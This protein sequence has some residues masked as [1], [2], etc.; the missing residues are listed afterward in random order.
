MEER[1]AYLE[2][3]IPMF[4][5]PVSTPT[6]L[7]PPPPLA[8]I[9]APSA[10]PMDPIPAIAERLDHVRI[11]CM[12]RANV[13]IRVE[14]I[15]TQNL[16]TF[17]GVFANGSLEQREEWRTGGKSAVDAWRG[18]F[19]C[20]PP[21]PPSSSTLDAPSLPPLFLLSALTSIRPFLPFLL[22][23]QPLGPSPPLASVH[24]SPLEIVVI[25][26]TSLQGG[27]G[28]GWGGG[29]LCLLRIINHTDDES[30]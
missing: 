16:I 19:W 8:A 3:F 6:H 7:P 11:F 17:T 29:L 20:R 10:F 1:S 28:G 4:F 9:A 24:P 18:D 27:W 12:L 15:N 5:F 26:V 14:L 2:G 30:L 22:S 25:A 23:P 13:C 21:P